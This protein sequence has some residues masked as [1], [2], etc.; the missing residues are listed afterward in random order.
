MNLVVLVKKRGAE[1]LDQHAK[2]D[3]ERSG[4]SKKGLRGARRTRR[5]SEAF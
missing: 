4:V 1:R 2:L 3:D 5:A